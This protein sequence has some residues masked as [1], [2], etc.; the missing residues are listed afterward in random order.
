[1][2]GLL[3]AMRSLGPPCARCWLNDAKFSI[4]MRQGS[5]SDNSLKIRDSIVV[6][7][8]ACHAE[9]PGSI[10][11]RGTLSWRPWRT[12][13]EGSGCLEEEPNNTCAKKKTTTREERRR[14]TERERLSERERERESKT[15]HKEKGAD[16][17]QAVGLE[18]TRSCLQWILSPPP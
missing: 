10:P 6:S 11:G 5:T 3:R 2:I 1:M 8:S 14:E 18:P 13:S 12:Q 15:K 7:I 17:V 4:I 16:N 9:D